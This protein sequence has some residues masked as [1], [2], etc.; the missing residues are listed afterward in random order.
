DYNHARQELL[1]ARRTLPNDPLPYLLLGYIDRRQGRWKESTA[2]MEYALELDPRNPQNVFILQ[3]LAKSHECLRNYPQTAATLRRALAIAPKDPITRVQLAKV[4][5]DW[6]ADLKPLRLTVQA[7]MAEQPEVAGVLARERI[8]VAVC[9]RDW[10]AAVAALAALTPNGCHDEAVMLPRGWCEGQIARFR[11]DLPGARRSF[12]T[13]REELGPIVKS[14]PDNGPMLCA[15]GI[16]DA[17]LGNKE[18]AVR[19]GRRAVELLP[20]EKDSINGA[21]LRQYLA[22]IYAWTGET[23]SAFEE[24]DQAT[25]LPGYLSYGQL[26]LDPIW[27]PLRGDAR[28]ENIVAALG[29]K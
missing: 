8:F 26:R 4:D 7:V 12:M 28:F 15:L 6:R 9:E 1:L 13:A 18:N 10:D 23:D 3:Q 22:I 19:E 2:N 5:L 21:L 27:D 16:L 29:P 20:V 25:K 11:G 14:Q 24:L 17:A